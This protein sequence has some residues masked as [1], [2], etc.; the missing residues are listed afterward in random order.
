MAQWPFAALLVCLGVAL[1][2]AGLF[3]WRLLTISSGLRDVSAWGLA[4][5]EH[6]LH[7]RLPHLTFTPDGQL[8]LD[9]V[10]PALADRP[11]GAAQGD[12]LPDRGSA[13]LA[14][15]RGLVRCSRGVDRAPFASQR[16]GYLLKAPPFLF[17]GDPRL[18]AQIRGTLDD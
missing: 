17:F 12:G 2:I 13:G 6:H 14:P 7:A 3:L 11:D 9:I 5:M 4:E 18:L 15:R 1:A 10:C 16:A 8:S